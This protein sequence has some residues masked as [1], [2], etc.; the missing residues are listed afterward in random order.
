MDTLKQDLKNVELTDKFTVSFDAKAKKAK[1][2]HTVKVTYDFTGF[3]VKKA[4]E[5]LAI[6]TLNIKAQADLKSKFMTAD[7]MRETIKKE[8]SYSALELI[9]PAQRSSDPM[10]IGIKAVSK[11]TPEQLADYMKQL[12]ALQAKSA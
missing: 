6:K 2:S 11:M 12:E 1:D 9:T 4:L 7:H 10:E 5:E 3:D 8:Y